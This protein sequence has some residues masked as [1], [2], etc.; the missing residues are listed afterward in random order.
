MKPEDDANNTFTARLLLLLESH[1]VLESFVYNEVIGSVIA[2]YWSDYEDHKDDFVPAFL[3]NDILRLWRTF[4]V[5]YEARTERVPEEK[6]IK[7]KTK[8]YKLKYSR[9]LTCYSALLYL[10]AMF[11][12]SGTVSPSDARSMTQLSPTQRLEWLMDQPELSSAHEILDGLLTQYDSFL[13]VASVG[14][15]ELIKQFKDKQVSHD[16]ITEA[17]K[18][19]D[20]I[21]AALMKIG[22]GSQLHRLLVV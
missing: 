21:F 19:G 18:F 7:R 8:N 22:D 4:C 1:A 2:A 11:Q 16:R 6:R 15:E 9:L 12:R 14:E 3:A 5:N 13:A 10:L 17:S 20:G